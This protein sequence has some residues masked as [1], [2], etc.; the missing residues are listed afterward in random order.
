MS[1]V[2]TKQERRE[3]DRKWSIDGGDERQARKSSGLLLVVENGRSGLEIPFLQEVS[4]TETRGKCT[5]ITGVNVLGPME[6]GI[7]QG[8]KGR[9]S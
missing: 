9:K 5:R 1:K 2:N 3:A 6:F 8:R 7:R 4:N